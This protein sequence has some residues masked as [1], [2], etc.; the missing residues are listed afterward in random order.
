MKAPVNGGAGYFHAAIYFTDLTNCGHESIL[1]LG[2]ALGC[3]MYS[4]NSE[5]IE[6]GLR[7]NIKHFFF[8]LYYIILLVCN[9]RHHFT[10]WVPLHQDADMKLIVSSLAWVVNVMHSCTVNPQRL[11]LLS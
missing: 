4:F 11:Y 8:G 1:H 7:E 2:F 3:L 6:E 5:N 10:L 9:L